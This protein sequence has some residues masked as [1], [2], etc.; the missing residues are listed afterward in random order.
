MY[1]RINPCRCCVSLVITDSFAPGSSGGGIS[2]RGQSQLPPQADTSAC[3]KH[4]WCLQIACT[5]TACTWAM[6]DTC[7]F[8]A[9]WRRQFCVRA[10][11]CVLNKIGKEK[12]FNLIIVLCTTKQKHM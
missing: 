7:C 1:V 12:T 4:D 9:Q 8:C 6:T 11:V 10:C 5:P 2:L 3:V